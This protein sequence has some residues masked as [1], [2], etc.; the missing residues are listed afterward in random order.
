[1]VVFI[2]DPNNVKILYVWVYTDEPKQYDQC[3]WSEYC[4]S[5][6]MKATC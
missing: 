6:S 2:L 3:Q 4:W 1:M 5:S